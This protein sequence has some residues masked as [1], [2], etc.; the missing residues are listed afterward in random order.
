[1]TQH[2]Q[3]HL[4]QAERTLNEALATT[5][6]I[7]DRYAEAGTLRALGDVY[8]AQG[9]I[10][11]ARDAFMRSLEIYRALGNEGEAGTIEG[12]LQTT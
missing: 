4:E 11:E 9:R 7:G 10:P 5:H 6:D 8:V 12:R 2:A 1:M 3:G